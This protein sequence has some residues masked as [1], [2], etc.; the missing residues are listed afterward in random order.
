MF[1]TADDAIPDIVSPNK[2]GLVHKIIIN[3]DPVIT[4][5]AIIIKLQVKNPVNHFNMFIKINEITKAISKQ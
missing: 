4:N 3:P 1:T 2:E 5:Q